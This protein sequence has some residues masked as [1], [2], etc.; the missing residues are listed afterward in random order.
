MTDSGDTCRQELCPDMPQPLSCLTSRSDQRPSVVCL[1]WQCAMLGHWW[2]IHWWQWTE[3]TCCVVSFMIAF[4]ICCSTHFHCGIQVSCPTI[5]LCSNATEVIDC[6]LTQQHIIFMFSAT[7]VRQ[8]VV[9]FS[10]ATMALAL[11]Y[12]IRIIQCAHCAS[13]FTINGTH[14]S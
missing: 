2:S 4:H 12:R 11:Q 7:P 5:I 10:L 8:S 1:F 6:T 9:L 14:C 3:T 13:K